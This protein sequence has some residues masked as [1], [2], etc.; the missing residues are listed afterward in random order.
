MSFSDAL[1]SE[2][3]ESLSEHRALCLNSAMRQTKAE[4]SYSENMDC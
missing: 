3:S 2:D 4:S 1:C